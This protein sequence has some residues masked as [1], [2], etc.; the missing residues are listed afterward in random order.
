MPCNEVLI[1]VDLLTLELKTEIHDL[2]RLAYL[3]EEYRLFLNVT[4]LCDFPE[5]S[6]DKLL[7]PIEGLLYLK[8]SRHA[9]IIF[10]MSA[11]S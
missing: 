9:K 8:S 11:M 10:K 5:C 1:T 2:Q 7:C 6:I 3:H 4:N